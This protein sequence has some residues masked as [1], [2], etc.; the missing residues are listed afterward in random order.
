MHYAMIDARPA[1]NKSSNASADVGLQHLRMSTALVPKR[2]QFAFWRDAF[3]DAVFG[4][5]SEPLA[6]ADQGFRAEAE[7]W[8]SPSLERF[9]CSAEN[10]MVSRG[11]RDIARRHRDRVW[12]YHEGGPRVCFE[13]G[14][15]EFVA[16]TGDLI[17]TDSDQCFGIKSDQAYRHDIWMLPKSLLHPSFAYRVAHSGFPCTMELGLPVCSLPISSHLAGI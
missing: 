6:A 12:I 15:R 1:G 14:G 4:L 8:I 3:R 17:I 2:E 16:G 5:F 13:Q 7:A 9:C 11:A 10:V